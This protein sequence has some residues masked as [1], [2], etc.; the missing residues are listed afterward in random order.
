MLEVDKEKL[1]L[2]EKQ[3]NEMLSECYDQKNREILVKRLMDVDE[4]SLSKFLGD[5]LGELNHVNLRDNLMNMFREGKAKEI[6]GDVVKDTN[7]VEPRKL[8]PETQKSLDALQIAPEKVEP[9]ALETW[10]KLKKRDLDFWEHWI[11]VVE[12]GDENATG[13]IQEEDI[14]FRKVSKKLGEN[15]GCSNPNGM[16]KRGLNR[17]IMQGMIFEGTYL[18]GENHG[19]RIQVWMEGS[20]SMTLHKKGQYVEFIAKKQIKSDF[21]TAEKQGKTQP[22]KQ[23]LLDDFKFADLLA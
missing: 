20:V 23:N 9:A 2:E 7:K 10:N 15:E 22:E 17:D 14:H 18:D 13:L 6:L 12:E 19:A 4:F 3:E 5:N 11:K 16:E 8:N 21:V 1:K